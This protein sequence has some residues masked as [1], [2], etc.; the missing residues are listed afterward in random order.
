MLLSHLGDLL[1]LGN[2]NF[3]CFSVLVQGLAPFGQVACGFVRL[4]DPHRI[5]RLAI[6]DP[7]PGN[8][9]QSRLRDV[10]LIVI[11]EPVEEFDIRHCFLCHGPVWLL[12]PEIEQDALEC[13]QYRF[14]WRLCRL[15]VCNV[16]F[17][18]LVDHCL[19]A[20]KM[21]PRQLKL[22]L[23]L[24]LQEVDFLCLARN[25]LCLNLSLSFILLGI[26]LISGDFVLLKLRRLCLFIQSRAELCKRHLQLSDL[27]SRSTQVVDTRGQSLHLPIVQSLHFL[28]VRQVQVDSVQE[29]LWCDI[30][31]T[32]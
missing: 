18:Q 7:K 1:L 16:I 28:Q 13:K 30:R 11:L 17:A 26:D 6:S 15:Q 23:S 5:E 20:F 27:L 9:I 4:A 31:A 12:V 10:V 14:R 19:G 2:D 29:A 8:S 25:F 3:E 22:L 21:G 24:L 32:S